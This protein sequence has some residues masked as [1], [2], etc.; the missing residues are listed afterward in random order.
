MFQGR[1]LMKM[2]NISWTWAFPSSYFH[3]KGVAKK[4]GMP[5]VNALIFL[6]KR[7]NDALIKP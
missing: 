4:M 2:L 7:G 1:H 5:Q 6:Y 3:K